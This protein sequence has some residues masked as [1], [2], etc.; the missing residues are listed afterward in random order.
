MGVRLKG[1]APR[2]RC[3][4]ENIQVIVKESNFKLDG[5]HFGVRNK[6]S[7]R[8]YAI[9]CDDPVQEAQKFYDKIGYGGQFMERGNEN[10]VQLLDGTI[11]NFRVKSKSGGPVVDINVQ[12]STDTCGIKTHKLHFIK[13]R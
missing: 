11:I 4:K 10:R 3:L 9:E 8:A 5:N 13:R 1:E 7:S 12:Y 6:R 2:A